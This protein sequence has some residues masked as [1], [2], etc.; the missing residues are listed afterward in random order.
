[1]KDAWRYTAERDRFREFFAKYYFPMMTRFSAGDLAELGD[2]RHGLF[3]K[4][5]WKATSTDL[6]NDLTEVAFEKMKPVMISKNYHPAVRY[7]AI[8]VL[9]LLDV[10]YSAGG[11]PSKP[12]A[13]AN[14]LLTQV[15][16][17]AASGKPVDPTLL[18]GALVG[19]ERHAQFHDGLERKEV[20]A[21]TTALL[22]LALV[23]PLMPQADRKVSEWIRVQTAIVLA[24][25]GS[26]GPNGEVLAALLKM[27]DGNSEPK[28]TLDARCQ[29]A[30]LLGLVNYQGATVDGKATAA[31]VLKLVTDVVAEEVKEAKS[32]E[33]LN[34]ASYSEGP[35]PRGR[36]K[37]PQYGG[38]PEYERRTLLARFADVRLCAGSHQ[39]DRAGG[40]AG[41][42][43]CHSG[44]DQAGDRRRREQGRNRSA[45]RP[46]DRHHVE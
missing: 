32:F 45:A 34:I 9:G 29:V 26:A 36:W 42:V 14:A 30:A 27:I 15:V 20:D 4:F 43:R 39:A 2:K 38:L 21:M 41:Y 6:Q 23:E 28:L 11:R 12:Y 22:K 25:L 37:M 46:K 1:M 13:K 3:D 10:Q 33:S 18:V 8:L 5:L 7:N 31:A 17:A 44:G 16:D 40:T 35:R 24:K 19:L